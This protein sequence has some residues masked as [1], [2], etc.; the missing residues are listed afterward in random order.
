MPLLHPMVVWLV[1]ALAQWMVPTLL[2]FLPR[3]LVF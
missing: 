2:N 1:S 3:P